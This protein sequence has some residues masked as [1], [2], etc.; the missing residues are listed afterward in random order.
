[1]R[2]KVTVLGSGGSKGVPLIGGD[3]GG[4]D[5]HEPRNGRT[6]PGVLVE[7]EGRVLLFDTSADL[8]AQLLAN[9]VQRVDAVIYTHVHADHVM[10]ID[11]VRQLAALKGG[12][13]DI[14][15]VAEDMAWLEDKFDYVFRGSQSGLYP[16]I[17]RAQVMER[18]EVDVLGIPVRRWAQDHHVCQ[19]QGFRIGPFGYTTDLIDLGKG[20]DHLAGVDTWC[21]SCVQEGPHPTHAPLSDVLGWIELVRPRRAYLTS[22]S[23][24]LDYAQLKARL[25]AHVTPSHDGLVIEVEG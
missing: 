1:M 8:R 22:M 11:E 3:W 16:A 25:P 4:C 6:R 5:P 24:R 7:V 14:F 19:S 9:G 15:A 12:P 18:E 21:V 23:D 13:V 17:G 20:A 10:G 2:I